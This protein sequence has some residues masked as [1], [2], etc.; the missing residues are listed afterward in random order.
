MAS[1]YKRG[2]SWWIAYYIAGKSAPVRRSLKTTN[3]RIAEREKQ[4][5]E[6]HLVES[7]RRVPEEK[8]PKFDEFW[9][10]YLSWAESGHLRPRTLDRKKD[11]WTQFC[12]SQTCE[13]MGDVTA[14]EVEAFKRS[15]RAAGNAPATINKALTDLQAIYARAAKLGLYTGPNPF[16]VTDRLRETRKVPLYHS[17]ADLIS[18]L[19]AATKKSQHVKWTVLL[20]GW[21][22]LR[23][24]E[25][26]NCRFEWF[27]FAN[28]KIRVKSF[29]GFNIKDHE[30]REIDM[31]IRIADEFQGL[32]KEEGFIFN[33]SR[34]SE[35]KSRYRFDPK[36][37]LLSL[38]KDVGLSTAKPF[39]RLRVTYGSILVAKGVPLKKVSRMMGHASVTT[40]EKHYVGIEPFDR[41]IDF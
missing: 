13:R 36:R 22:G 10:H 24:N 28:R 11:F 6:A 33:I 21:A 5:L 40:T 29:P 14:G 34:P 4:A 12:D 8:N 25:L 20:C 16:R 19:D 35:G 27:D 18:L 38:L 9:P 3:R 37:A 32:A 30:E 17:E 15:R 41:R 23:R 26:V 7:F 2:K 39:Q 31:S 1:I